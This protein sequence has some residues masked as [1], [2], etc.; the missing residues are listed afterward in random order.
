MSEAAVGLSGKRRKSYSWVSIALH[1]TAAVGFLVMF[2]IG[3]T[4]EEM[5]RGPERR[6]VLLFHIALGM[7]LFPL[8]AGRVIWRLYEGWPVEPDQP[9]LL[10]LLGRW[11]PRLLLLN[12]ALQ[13]VTGP[14]AVWTGGNPIDVFGLFSI[15][16]VTGKIQIVHRLAETAHVIGAKTWIPLLALHVLGA[17]KHHF[18]DRDRVLVRMV[19]GGATLDPP[20]LSPEPVARQG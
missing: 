18:Y 12:V 9:L 19:R 4:F 6:E 5:P 1:W 20:K 7:T 14:I 2:Y 13:A 3:N 17:L 16:S 11:V 8:F 15:P 10:K